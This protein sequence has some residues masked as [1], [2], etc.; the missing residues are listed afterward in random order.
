MNIEES[1]VQM[2]QKVI[3]ESP[4]ID[5]SLTH[6]AMGNMSNEIKSKINSHHHIATN[7]GNNYH[8]LSHDG[9]TIYYRHEN[10]LKEFSYIKHNV[11]AGTDKNGGNSDNI[12]NFMKH[13][14]DTYGKLASDNRN[15]NGSKKL[16]VDF[17][18]KNKNYKYE[19]WNTYTKDKSKIDHTN[20]DDEANK[21]WGIDD[22]YKNI[23]I[24]ATK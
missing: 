1:Y 12:H 22:V 14:I 19:K 13:H 4:M 10:G 21:I 18:K 17:I 20:I 24:L 3:L 8:K 6:K 2:R 15:T 7:I 5:I 9:G 16:W 23:R 11:Q